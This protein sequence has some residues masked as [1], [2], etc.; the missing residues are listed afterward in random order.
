MGFI[1]ICL[2]TS[3]TSSASSCFLHA[4]ARK[5]HRIRPRRFQTPVGGFRRLVFGSLPLRKSVASSSWCRV[6]L[7]TCSG[8]S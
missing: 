1:A 8:M 5:H 2:Q 4:I 3:G 7:S 6:S